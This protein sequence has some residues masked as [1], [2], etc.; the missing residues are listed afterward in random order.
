MPENSESKYRGDGARGNI[1]SKKKGRKLRFLSKNGESKN[2]RS[3]ISKG[4]RST[5]KN[6]VRDRCTAERGSRQGSS[7][8]A[9]IE[10]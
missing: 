8:G 4:H 5:K 1:G 6:R 9:N 10:K 7:R 3:R 2:G